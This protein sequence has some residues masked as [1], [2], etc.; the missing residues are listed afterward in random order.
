MQTELHWE[1]N[2]TLRRIKHQQKRNPL[3]SGLSAGTSGTKIKLT[4]S[5]VGQ[6][7]ESVCEGTEAGLVNVQGSGGRGRGTRREVVWVSQPAG[8]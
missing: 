1:N 4:P 6:F 7:C 8:H 5:H 3:L 2:V